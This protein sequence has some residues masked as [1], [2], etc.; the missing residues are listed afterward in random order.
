MAVII[1][2]ILAHVDAGKTILT[3]HIVVGHGAITTRSAT[4]AFPL[5][6]RTVNLTDSPRHGDVVAVAARLR[7]AASLPLRIL[8]NTIDR[9]GACGKARRFPC[10]L[11][12]R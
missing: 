11:F 5:S 9:L 4:F 1:L 10:T 3:E 8:V 6:T 2:S 7:R 12:E